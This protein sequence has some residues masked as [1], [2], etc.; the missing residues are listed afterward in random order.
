ML[1]ALLLIF[2]WGRFPRFL[3]IST[4]LIPLVLFCV[5]AVFKGRKY[6]WGS[7]LLCLFFMPASLGAL[8]CSVCH[9]VKRSKF[10]GTVSVMAFFAALSVAVIWGVYLLN[11]GW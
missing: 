1:A 3:K 2:D 6:P 10:Y 5:G 4:A 8:R 7:M 9:S 11:N